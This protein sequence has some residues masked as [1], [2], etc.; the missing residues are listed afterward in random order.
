[1]STATSTST[2]PGLQGPT[3]VTV[4][5]PVYRGGKFVQATI[6]ALLSQT[7]RDMRVLVICDGSPDVSDHDL[8]VKYQ[9]QIDFVDQ[10]NL[11]L[12]GTLN[13]AINDLV[14]TPFVARCDQDDI[15]HPT[16][17]E[18]QMCALTDQQADVCFTKI[19]KFVQAG[20]VLAVHPDVPEALYLYDPEVHGAIVHSTLLARTAFLQQLGGYRKELYP[21]DD[22]DLCLRMSKAGHVIVV[23]RSLVDYRLHDEANTFKYFWDMQTKTNYLLWS[24]RQAG[25]EISYGEWFEAHGRIEAASIRARMAGLGRLYYRQAGVRLGSGKFITGGGLLAL[26]SMLAPS[27][28]LGRLSNMVKTVFTR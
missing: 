20:R 10:A 3:S 17:I 18:E 22:F 8:G 4:I 7:Y 16:R 25:P 21:C 5:V 6:D 13:Y 26:S 27:F 1:M 2:S 24:Y 15:S 14:Q 11:G 23:G 19:N 28:T 9:G 12:C